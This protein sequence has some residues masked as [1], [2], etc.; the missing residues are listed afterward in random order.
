M[1]PL[2]DLPQRDNTHDTAQAA[3]DAL[4]QAIN[5]HTFFVVQ[6]ADRNDYGTDVQIEARRGK[7]MTNV[8]IHA[9]LKGTGGSVNPDGSI[10]VAVARKNLNYLLNQ[11]SSL[12]VCYH[13]PSRRLLVRSAE[14]V[15]RE[16]EHRGGDWMQQDNITVRFSEAFDAQFQER[17]NARLVASNKE[18]RDYRLQWVVTPPEQVP[19]LLEHM[20]AP[21]IVPIEPLQAR[22][23]L[24]SLY[25]ARQDIAISGAFAQFAAVLNNFP[26]AMDP[27]YMAEINLGLN[28]FPCN[29]ERI[30]QSV[31]IIDE[32]MNWGDAHRGSLLYC[33]GN[34]FLALGEHAEGIERY[35]SALALLDN[36]PIFR[37]RCSVQ[38]ELG[39][40]VRGV[41]RTR[42]R[43]CLL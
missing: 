11:P 6:R 37:H 33:Q 42:F 39:L 2:D 3:E 40:S 18:A 19:A 23:L 5:A 9:Q 34:A 35:R 14:D 1:N 7:A 8:R 10:S 32:A 20:S 21:V 15:F 13:L 26:G 31:K 43:S 4:S 28:A 30:R 16:Y 12:Y 36:P 41:G 25:A 22:E 38:Q 27:A 29:A 24:S 17:M